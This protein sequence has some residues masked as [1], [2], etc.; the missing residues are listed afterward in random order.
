MTDNRSL[1]G[2]ETTYSYEVNSLTLVQKDSPPHENP[3]YIQIVKFTGGD[4]RLQIRVEDSPMSETVIS[5][6]EFLLL[7][8]T[9]RGILETPGGARIVNM[10]G[11]KI[12]I[13]HFENSEIG[14]GIGKGKY[15]LQQNEAELLREF[16]L[17]VI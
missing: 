2:V 14:F 3:F 7:Q 4:I 6:K 15:L 16:C 5:K 10:A 17:R 11:N 13:L 1:L 9:I 12:Q 8:D